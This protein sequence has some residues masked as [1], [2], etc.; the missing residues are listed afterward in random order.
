MPDTAVEREIAD[1]PMTRALDEQFMA[2]AVAYGRRAQGRTWPNPPVGAVIVRQGP[3]GPVVVGRGAT[4]PPGGPHAEVVALEQAGDA[5][6]G[7]TAYVT[8]EP[9]AHQGRTG[10]CA[11]ALVKAGISRVVYGIADPNPLVGGKGHGILQENGIAVTSGVLEKEC[12][13]AVQGHLSRVEKGRPHLM[14]KMAISANGY[15][16]QTGEG[17]LAISSALSKR[18]V[19]GLRARFDGILIGIGTVLEDDPELTCRLPGMIGQSPVRI[20]LDSQ[21][22]LPLDSK[23]VKSCRE[24]PLWVLTGENASDAR[25]SAL[26]RLGVTVINNDCVRNGHVCL[27]TVLSALYMRGLSQV[28]VE[29]GA[30]IAR[31][32]LDEKVIDEAI[33]FKGQSVVSGTGILPFLDEGVEALDKTGRFDRKLE[34][35][36][37]GDAVL[38]YRAK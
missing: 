5:A 13:E 22:R 8:L 16:G 34:R 32:M 11:L 28:L 21:A 15:I 27:D 25:V 6:R 24:V 23:L 2:A 14:L 33:I 38:H 36:S 35:Y 9:C 29:G 31:A 30:H 37:G 26:E 17:Q 7:A 19:H 10:P 3:F 12:R 18:L 20:V 4:M 1:G